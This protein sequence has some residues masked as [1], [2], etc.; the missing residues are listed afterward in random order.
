M[1][2]DGL[3]DLASRIPGGRL[4]S[5]PVGHLIHRAA[6]RAFAEAV[7]AFLRR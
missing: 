3:A 6:P 2:Q 5:I 1:P 7:S 4:V